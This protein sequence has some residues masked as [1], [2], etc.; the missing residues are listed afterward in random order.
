MKKNDDS[1]SAVGDES[2]SSKKDNLLG[3]SLNLE[4]VIHETYILYL[5]FSQ[6]QLNYSEDKQ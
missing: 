6:N 2:V 4:I 3:Q 1:A 5:S